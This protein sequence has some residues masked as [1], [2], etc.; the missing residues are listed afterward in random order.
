MVLVALEK[1]LHLISPQKQTV[2]GHSLLRLRA[3]LW[4]TH[5]VIIP[6]VRVRLKRRWI[7]FVEHLLPVYFLQPGMFHQFINAARPHSL[8]RFPFQQPIDKC[9]RIVTPPLRQ[10]MSLNWCF[11]EHHLLP[12]LLAVVASVRSLSHQLYTFPSM[13]SY[14]ITPS[15]KK[16]TGK[17]WFSLFMTS[18][19]IYPGVPEV[20]L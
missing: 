2:F 9:K 18:G 7:F 14:A 17:E 20:S 8:R 6:S 19:A 15:A 10:L 5:C 3:V 13:H 11:I 12:Y 16:S 1:L 4:L